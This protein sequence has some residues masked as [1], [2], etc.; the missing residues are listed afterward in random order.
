LKEQNNEGENKIKT[1]VKPLSPDHSEEET[2]P[3][4][5]NIKITSKMGKSITK[6]DSHSR[7]QKSNN[8]Q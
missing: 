4:P 1:P 7:S 6:G 3:S 2:F 5:R 8:H